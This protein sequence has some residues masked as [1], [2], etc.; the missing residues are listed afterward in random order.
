MLDAA[1]EKE[2]SLS[3]LRPEIF[4]FKPKFA[5]S[6]FQQAPLNVN[7]ANAYFRE[8]SLDTKRCLNEAE[9]TA[10]LGVLGKQ[11]AADVY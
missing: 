6:L 5:K 1:L 2:L 4:V 3:A 10:A 11:L 9:S 7:F 8:I